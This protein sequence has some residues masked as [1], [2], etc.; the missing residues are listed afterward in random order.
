[1]DERRRFNTSERVALYLA[2]DGKCSG[3]GIEL[4]PGWHADHVQPW[5]RGGETDV[6]NAQAMCV[7][8]NLK[9]GSRMGREW[10]ESRKLR[11]WQERAFRQFDMSRDKDFLLV[12]C[13]GAGKTTAALRMAMEELAVG[14]ARRIVVVCP[15]EHLKVQWAEAASSVGINLDPFWS[16]GSM[17][18]SRDYDGVAAT[19][20]QVACNPMGFRMLCQEPTF[21]IFD[22][23]HHAGDDASWGEALKAGFE[24]ATRRLGL[25]GTPFRSRGA[26]PF[27][28]YVNDEC[29]PDFPYS[30]G[31]ALG[32]NVCRPIYFPTYEGKM[33]WY[34][35]GKKYASTFQEKLSEAD[36]ARRL[37]TSLLPGGD[38]LR[39]VIV[40]GD[41]KLNAIRTTH[42]DA[43]GLVVA[44]NIDH[45]T[46]IA[47]RFRELTGERPVVVHSD[48]TESSRLIKTFRDSSGR[49][50]I[51]VKMISEGVDIPRLRV[52]IY[53][54]NTTTELFFRQ[55]AGRFVR[56]IPDLEDQSAFLLIPRD[57]VFVDMIRDIQRTRNDILKQEAEEAI[58][59]RPGDDK[60]AST[61]VPISSTGEAH[62][63]FHP[64]GVSVSQSEVQDARKF[65]AE[66]GAP[67]CYDAAMI[68]RILRVA[69]GSSRPAEIFATPPPTEKPLHD[70][71]KEIG[72]VIRKYV[73]QVVAMTD[74]QH[75]HQ[76]VFTE[77]MKNDGLPQGH[78]TLDQ[79]KARVEF[80][81]RWQQRLSNG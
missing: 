24:R 5:S 74:D 64:D 77:L 32:D 48:N 8:C 15:T 25:S 72:K 41:E 58:S 39:E 76:S 73:S 2:S 11:P 12:A 18:L 75:T 29:A 54:T 66:A 14:R 28:K 30:Y 7:T 49:W 27:V 44:M 79:L 63:V 57:E 38:W 78:C 35:K 45:A 42:P 21:G 70:Q 17:V 65:M 26:I 67:I 68:A 4:E 10:P 34:N 37:R 33:E 55:F 52:G 69:N 71:K 50:I 31:D 1:M 56:M 16:N 46:A 40:G 22:E 36:A 51:A 20:A 60:V 3:C 47:N 43:A 53:A 6:I 61:F 81:V 59:E 80:L 19:Y 62:D 9:K 23:I 13:P